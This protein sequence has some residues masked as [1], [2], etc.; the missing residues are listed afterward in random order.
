MQEKMRRFLVSLGLDPTP[1]FM[2]EFQMVGRDP[3]NHNN[4]IMSI[5][6]EKPWEASSLFRFIEAIGRLDY[7]TSIRFS[8]V[9]KPTFDDLKTL[10]N[11]YEIYHHTKGI[12]SL[13]DLGNDR[14][15]VS[16]LKREKDGFSSIFNDFNG[17]LQYIS[18]SFTLEEG[19]FQEVIERPKVEEKSEK[20][21]EIN[22]EDSVMEMAIKE[23]VAQH[24]EAI[25]EERKNAR[26]SRRNSGPSVTIHSIREIFSLSSG[27]FSFAGTIFSVDLRMSRKGKLM[28]TFGVMDGG[29]AIYV[30]VYENETLTTDLLKS[31]SEKDRVRVTGSLEF[32]SRTNERQVRADNLEKLAPLPL[33]EDHAPEKRVELHLHTKMS[34]MDG[35][36]EILDYCKVAKNMGMK[37]LAVTD[38]GVI[39]SFPA[40]E[41]A[42]KKTGIKIIYGCEFNVFD[43]PEYIMNP[44]PI[45]LNKARYC[46]LD[47]ETTGLSTR[48]DRPTE[49]GGV[50]VENGTIIDRLDQFINPGIKIPDF[51]VKKTRITNEMVMNAPSLKEAEKIISD[52][53]GD[54]IIVSHNAPFDVGF[55]NQL[56]KA[57]GKPAL[58]NPVIDTLALSHY[59]FPEAASHR[60]GSLSK[61]LNLHIYDEDE[62]HRADYDAEVL[63]DVWQ[64]I[65]PRLLKDNYDLTHAELGKLKSNNPLMFRHLRSYHVIA[66]AKNQEG[67]KAL[68]RLVSDSHVKY[69]ARDTSPRIPRADLNKERA[70]LLLGSACFNGDVFEA[71]GHREAEFLD[72]KIK[73]YN[74]IELQPRENYSFLVNTEAYTEERLNLTLQAIVDESE[75]LGKMLVATG[76]AHYVNPEDKITRDIYISAKGLGNTLHPLNPRIRERLPAFENPDQHFRSTEEMLESF[77]EWLPEEKAY[78]MVITNSN[79]IADQCEP[80]KILKDKLY[81]PTANLPG[82][83][84]KIREICEENLHKKYGENPDPLIVERLEKELNGIISNGYSVTYYIAHLIVKKAH[85]DGYVVGSRGSVGS[86]FAATM[87]GITEVNPLPPHYLCPHCHHL[88]WSNDEHIRSG[89]DLAPKKCPVCGTMMEG[90]GQDIPFETFLGF[91]AEKVPDIDLNFPKDYQSRAHA[92]A[93]ELLSSK[94]EN[95][96][97]A[98]G[99][100]LDSPHVIRAGTIATAEEKNA[101]GYVRGY[102]ERVLKRDWSNPDERAYISSLAKRCVGVKRTTGQHPGGIVVIPSNMEIFDFTPYQHPADDPDA[103]WLT[104]HYEFASMHDSVLKLDLLGH[105]DPMALRMMSLSTHVALE[106]IPLNDP[107]VLS[108]FSSA[109]ELKLKKNPLNFKTG[110]IALPEFGTSFVQGILEEASPKSFNDLLVISGLSHGTEVWQNNAQDLLRQKTCSLSDVIGCRDD[111]MNYLIPMGVPSSS[112]FQIME[113]VR[114]GKGLKP[115]Q[116][117]LMRQHHVPEWYIRSCN[118]IHYLFPR[119]HATA[120]VIGAVRVAWF[121]LYHPLDFYATYFSTRCDK[122]DILTMSGGYD[123]ILKGIVTLNE[124]RD[125]RDDFKDKDEEILKGLIAALEMVDRGYNIE[126]ISLEKSLAGT[127]SVDLEKNAIV[128]PFT[129]LSGLGLQAA[130]TVVEARKDGK[131]LSKE[132]LH[133]R[134]QLTTSDIESLSSIG[135]LDGL[136]ESNQMSLFEFLS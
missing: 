71:A 66:L 89:F 12:C 127:W 90:D 17:L 58:K 82:S 102:F 40:A 119:A 134:T 121:K 33:R 74:Y 122:F 13:T 8:Y 99:E 100:F 23:A 97:I 31:F 104:T 136:G 98:R 67:L 109:D 64:A 7:E 37:A 3:R 20:N 28:G 110:S 107:R 101:I 45:A 53:V 41:N 43:D 4:V 52:F 116:E 69:L 115:E 118:H 68:Y 19:E 30:R 63:N 9:E 1:D 72:E 55:L 108:L 2:M 80:L 10:F 106:D 129:V 56:R 75:K 86:S 34:A 48:F 84:K 50:I 76:D 117:K 46:L 57:N 120:Y 79:L 130:E 94:E 25:S 81:P 92:Y 44:A 59:L 61:N 91:N 6:K 105:L 29:S 103:D 83:E 36:G 87:A 73:F 95:E 124:K 96:K 114:H 22:E 77:K 88:E 131:F 5:R 27:H 126:N 60:L 21:E 111:I 14:I 18:Y 132:D 85:E 125:K 38:H 65:L 32:D 42:S 35:L 70:N 93:R 51:I 39:Q 62:A 135:A 24:I 49:F 123:K 78:Q 128:P 26:R 11:E 16:P 15:L 133:E 112:A 54:A 47:F 113:D